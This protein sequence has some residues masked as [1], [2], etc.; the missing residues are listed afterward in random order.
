VANFVDGDIPVTDS[1]KKLQPTSWKLC[2]I[3]LGQ[4]A[5]DQPRQKKMEIDNPNFLDGRMGYNKI[6][7]EKNST[8]C[9]WTSSTCSDQ[10][11]I[12][13]RA[14]YS[15]GYNFPMDYETALVIFP[16]QSVVRSR[17]C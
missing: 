3:A 11:Q 15:L 17:Q 2:E 8:A 14:H 6:W 16:S 10:N 12:N 1:L 9:G 5:L 13:L 7:M 4:I